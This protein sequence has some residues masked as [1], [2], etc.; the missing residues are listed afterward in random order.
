MLHAALIAVALA[1]PSSAA[2][3][4]APSFEAAAAAV[5]A[6]ARTAA[7]KTVSSGVAARMD[8]LTWDV[9]DLQTRASRL[10][11][12]AR[13]V[14]QRVNAQPRP[15]TPNDPGLQFAVDRLSRD[16]QD[17]VMDL[18]RASNDAAG[19]EAS[20]AAKDPSLSSHARDLDDAAGWLRNEVNWLS[21]E[22]NFLGVDLRQKGWSMEAW[23]IER[24]LRDSDDLSRAVKDAT[25]RVRAKAG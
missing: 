24:A 16:L 23:D 7:A 8:R 11:S 21:V 9:R 12:D 5:T 6:A 13:M 18:R 4:A 10:R 25:A 14:D 1:A 19:I 2:V 15:G 3:P 17:L 22:N 20:V